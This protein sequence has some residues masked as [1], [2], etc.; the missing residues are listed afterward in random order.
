MKNKKLKIFIYS[1]I[2]LI[3]ISIVSVALYIYKDREFL[4]Y[5]ESVNPIELNDD[6][7]KIGIIGDSWVA[8]EK[9]DTQI[10]SQLTKQGVDAD[11]ISSGHPG[12]NSKKILNNLISE[13]GDFSSN[14][15]LL[16]EDVKYIVIIAG[17]NDTAGHMGKDF[18]S[19]HVSEIT[20][21]INE[22]GKIP[23]ILEVPEY[24]IEE[25]E[26]FKSALKHNIYKYLFDNGNADVIE[27]YRDQ[28]SEKL[29]SSNLTYKI[30]PF[31]PVIED[32]HQ[33]LELYQDPHHLNE[34]GNE[35]L[36]EYIASELTK[37]LK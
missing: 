22:S 1:A 29:K 31:P 11:V 16:D 19:H 23:I 25:P 37:L 14:Y 30:I 28:L 33:S 32:Y 17:V 18:Y 2:L 13:Q 9:L 21:I 4:T 20:R 34:S 5:T 6:T 15:I 12:A 10:K 24:G 26:A 27:S 36:A 7:V 8:S 3:V 35:I